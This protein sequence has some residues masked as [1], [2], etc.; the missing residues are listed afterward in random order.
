MAGRAEA[1]QTSGMGGLPGFVVRRRLWFL[2]SAL[3]L[4]AFLVPGVFRLGIGYSVESFL[5]TGNRELRKA[6]E[7]Y[8]EYPL[9]DALCFFGVPVDRP[10]AGR[11]LDLLDRFA[12]GIAEIP[13]VARVLTL[14]N[15][16]GLAGLSGED[17]RGRLASSKTYRRLL[18]DPGRGGG[19][20]AYAGFVQLEPS[21]RNT[22]GRTRALAAIRALAASLP[23]LAEGEKDLGLRLLGIPALRQTYVAHVRRDQALFLPLG[24]VLTS[25]VLFWIVRSTALFLAILSLVP[26]TLGFT[27]GLLGWAGAELTL[28]TSTL[29]TLLMV[30]SVA[31]A[32]HQVLRA[33]EL[34]E[35]GLGPEEATARALGETFFPCLLTSVTTAIGFGSLVLTEIPDLRDFGLFASLGVGVA[36][37]ATVL[38]LPGILLLLLRV[39]GKEGIRAGRSGRFGS[40]TR[41]VGT[42]PT[43]LVLV[44]FGLLVILSSAL[45]FRVDQDSY[46]SEDLW[47]DDPYLQDQ[48]WFEERFFPPVVGEILC[49]PLSAAASERPLAVLVSREF[50]A[51]VRALRREVEAIPGIVR[52][53]SYLDPLDDGL[54]PALLPLLAREPFSLLAK[55]GRSFRILVFMRDMGAKRTAAFLERIRALGSLDP[56]LRFRP[57][58]IQVLANHQVT[59]LIDEVEES[60]LLA[61]G[62]ISLLLAFVFGSPRFGLIGILPNI[63]PLILVLGFMGLS[64]IRLRIVVV[65]TF[66]I[67]FGL[68]VD[69]TI[70]ILSRYRRELGE[71]LHPREALPR[72]LGIV[73][74]A[75]WTT[76]ILLLAGFAVT[77]FSSFRA[78]F[79]FGRLACLTILG[80]LA[81]DLCLLPALLRAFSKR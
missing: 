73:G 1:G 54:P 11:S 70:H 61:F 81:G 46:L 24:A 48:R 66:A 56:S 59:T 58:G 7:H 34:L 22:R 42:L 25:V 76:S 30:I 18:L 64:G 29:P 9:P 12:E 40:L 5:R 72:S 4:A 80:A 28:F 6:L 49:E 19:P 36:F 2:I 50:G 65:I 8:G 43:R 52:T 10:F 57:V 47:E 15:A 69:N 16:P 27:F 77:L 13:G 33:G 31:D 79:D 17:L 62:L 44:L 37:F 78:T 71:G 39:L 75:V 63:F 74:P 3:L 45:A 55:D 51:R 60:F 21:T 41:V 35:G 20:G 32:V 67:S 68:A 26:I 23:P 14:R 38:F 53:L